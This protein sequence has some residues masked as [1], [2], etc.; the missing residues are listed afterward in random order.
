MRINLCMKLPRSRPTNFSGRWKEETGQIIIITMVFFFLP[1]RF[2]YLTYN[3]SS[4]KLFYPEI[5]IDSQEVANLQRSA[6]CS[7]LIFSQSSTLQDNCMCVCSVVSNL[8]DLMG[9]SL[10][11]SSVHGIF[12][13]RILE[14]VAISF[15][16]RSSRPRDRTWVSCISRIGRW[17]LYCW[18]TWEAN[19]SI[20][21]SGKWHWYDP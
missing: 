16:R 10:P 11:G 18:A 20:S 21:K 3:S 15:S 4:H 7:L 19:G 5:I 14:W 9:Y 6:M 2:F 1:H 13:A 12:Q 17:I 8:C